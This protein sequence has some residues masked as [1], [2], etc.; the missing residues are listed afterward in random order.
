MDKGW[1]RMP[2]IAAIAPKTSLILSFYQHAS[3]LMLRLRPSIAS[4]PNIVEDQAALGSMDSHEHFSR[5][6]ILP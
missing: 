3:S 5:T 4:I 2:I 1:F 6:G